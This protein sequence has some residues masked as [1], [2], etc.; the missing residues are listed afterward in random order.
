[1]AASLGGAFIHLGVAGPGTDPLRANMGLHVG[2]RPA[3]VRARRRALSHALG[4]SL[5]WMDQ[6]H[7]TTVALVNVDTRAPRSQADASGVPEEGTWAVLPADAVV[8]DARGWSSAPGAAVMVADCLPVLLAD[9]TGAVVAAVHAG[10]RGLHAG[11]LSRAVGTMA[12]LVG[13][14]GNL[15]ALIGPSICGS[16]YEVPAALREEVARTH[17]AAWAT[18]SWGTPSLDLAAGAE[19]ELRGLGLDEVRRDGRCTR[20]DAELHSHR[21][22]PRSGRQVDVVVPALPGAAC[23]DMPHSL[24]PVAPDLH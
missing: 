13:G 12:P 17:P 24:D 20:E 10:R 1:M 4:R 23:H 3:L 16:C 19:Q 18:T 21:R 14:G 9:T 11:I 6:T 2:D 22:D 15:H 5:V 7:S 8:V